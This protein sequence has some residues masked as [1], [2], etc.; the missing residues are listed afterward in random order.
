[1]DVTFVLLF[2]LYVPSANIRIYTSVFV[3]LQHNSLPV[4][5]ERS[6]DVSHRHGCKTRKTTIGM[7]EIKSAF[8]KINFWIRTVHCAQCTDEPSVSIV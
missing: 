3:V 6:T 4:M 2:S 1:M 5:F 7:Q 8:F